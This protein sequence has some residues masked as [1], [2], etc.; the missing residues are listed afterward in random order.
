MES[1]DKPETDPVI[2]YFNGGPGVA[3][4]FLAFVGLGPY[5]TLDRQSK[6]T[7]WDWSWNRRANLLLIDNPAG[8]GYSYAERSIDY[9]QTDY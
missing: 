5:V 3:S 7:P 8:L 6:L 2:I 4:I 1:L 9:N